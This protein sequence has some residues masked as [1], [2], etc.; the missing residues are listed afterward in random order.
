MYEAIG[1][2]ELN[3]IARGIAAADA[4][5]KASSADLFSAKTICP[6]KFA[7]LLRGDVAAVEASLAAGEAEGAGSIVDRFLIPNIHPQVLPALL[8]TSEVEALLSL[9]IIESYSAV[10]GI[11][12]AD[13]AVKAANV[14]LIEIRFAN[15]IGGKAVVLLTG[16]VAEV[17]C[18]VQ[19]GQEAIA[20][21]GLFFDS[22]V[23]PAPYSGLTRLL[24]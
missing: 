15:G 12:A 11:L 4:M 13:A 18:A 5:G 10:T 17:Q 20:H 3:G 9:G 23:I 14:D 24:A 1:G 7:I 2:L 22:T 8:G 6:G 19:A 21:T 16:D